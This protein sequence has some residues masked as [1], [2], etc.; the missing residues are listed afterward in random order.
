MPEVCHSWP[1]TTARKCQAICREKRR[2][3]ALTERLRLLT[4]CSA[5]AVLE[6]SSRHVR[7][8]FLSVHEDEP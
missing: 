7:G 1:E 6:G 4:C 5:R 3:D 2:V 8:M